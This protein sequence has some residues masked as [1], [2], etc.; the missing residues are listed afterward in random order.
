[1]EKILITGIS[2]SGKSFSLRNLVPEETFFIRGTSKM[3][4]AIK[5][6]HKLFIPLS[7]DN[8]EGNMV[9]LTRPFKENEKGEWESQMNK[10]YKIAIE[11]KFKR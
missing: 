3:P 5:G 8:K 10:L 1:M 9:T 6:A 7:K 2:G 4:I 11:R